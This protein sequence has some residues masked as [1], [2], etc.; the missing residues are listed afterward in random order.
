[1][2]AWLNGGLREKLDAYGAFPW[3]PTAF[4]VAADI[5]IE[6]LLSSPYLLVLGVNMY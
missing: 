1:M 2:I 6:V 3:Y 4:V 5:V